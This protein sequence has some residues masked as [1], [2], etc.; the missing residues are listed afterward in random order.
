MFQIQHGVRSDPRLSE[1]NAIPSPGFHRIRRI[2]VGSERC[3]AFLLQYYKNIR[4]DHLL[5]IL[6][7]RFN[8]SHRHRSP[9]Y[10]YE[11]VF[12][13]AFAA[14]LPLLRQLYKL[15]RNNH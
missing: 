13:S 11:S 6:F 8:H 2:R 3:A 15:D 9:D 4:I 14:K 5:I 7:G 1:S 10:I 12:E